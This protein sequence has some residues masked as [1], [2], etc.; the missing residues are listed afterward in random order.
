[1][2]PNIDPTIPHTM[3]GVAS[4]IDTRP[5]FIYIK[6][7]KTQIGSIT[8]IDVAWAFFLSIPNRESVGTISMPPPAPSKPFKSPAKKPIVE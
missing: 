1:M 4:K 5:L 3:Y 8:Q 2:A 6:E 7:L